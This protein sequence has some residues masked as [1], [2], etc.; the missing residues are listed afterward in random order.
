MLLESFLARTIRQGRLT[1]VDAAGR[2]RSFGAGGAPEV[3]IRLRDRRLA[4]Q[5]ALNPALIAGEAYMDG[6]LTIED[7]SLYDFLDLAATNLSAIQADPLLSW[8]RF[9]APLKRVFAANPLRRARRNVA[10]HY[11]LSDE[12]YALFLDAGRHYSCAYFAPGVTSLEEA[13]Q[14]KLRHIAAKLLL[15]RPGLEVWDIGSGWGGMG[16]YLAAQAGARVTGVTLSEGQHRVSNARAREAHL[17]QQVR[18]FLR[19][20]RQESGIFDRIVSV[21]MFEHVGARHLDEFFAQLGRRLK[22]DGVALL[23]SIGNMG[24]PC[25]VNPWITK[26][27]FPGGYLP[28]L[29]ETLAAIERAGLWV[30]D[31]EILRLHYAE[32]LLAWRQRFAKNRARVKALYDERFCRMWEFYLTASEVAFRRQEQMVFQIQLTHRR[33]AVPIT[34]DYIQDWERDLHAHSRQAAE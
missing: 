19:D 33:D 24:M 4:L 11:D 28:A 18:F 12:L 29:S 26:Y 13:Q 5:L 2:R 20:Y 23:H 34:R 21:G 10:H 15:D 16:L 8:A 32:T 9:L 30:T 3:T 25:P 27:I 14:A 17:D 22:P 7:G 1:V 6:R 31:I